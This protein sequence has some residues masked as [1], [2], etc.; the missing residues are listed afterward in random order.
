M[1][2]EYILVS[3]SGKSAD[4]QRIY[5]PTPE[6]IDRAIDA[7][8]PVEDYFVIL[9]GGRN[10]VENCVYIQTVIKR[11]DTEKIV[12]H[13]ELRFEY[14]KEPADQICEYKQLKKYFTD[15]KE[16]KKMFRMFALGVIPQVSGWTDITAE[17]EAKKEAKQ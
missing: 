6:E 11:D 5:D 2:E 17:M 12:Y 3:L 16:V 9:D 1:S 13:V 14:S 15:E 8:I 7:L 10:P 4:Y